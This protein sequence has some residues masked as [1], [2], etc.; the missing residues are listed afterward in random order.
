MK[1]IN[2]TTAIKVPVVKGIENSDEVE[3]V[4][5][6]F[7]LTDRILSSGNYGLADTAAVTVTR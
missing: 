5:P 3:I 7:L 1:L 4:E 6:A 2:D